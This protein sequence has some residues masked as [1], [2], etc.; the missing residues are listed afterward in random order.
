MVP[1]SLDVEAGQIHPELRTR[2]LEQMVGQLVSDELVPTCQ[3]LTDEAQED[4]V[5]RPEV[6]EVAGVVHLLVELNVEWDL[7]ELFVA[8]VN[9]PLH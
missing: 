6:V 3:L 5:N 7:A 8:S 2:G 1:S 9:A 4:P